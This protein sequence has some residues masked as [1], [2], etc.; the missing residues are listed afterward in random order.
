MNAGTANDS[1]V[2]ADL[3]L[4]ATGAANFFATMTLTET[5]VGSNI[6]TT[7]RFKVELVI[8]TAIQ[9]LITAWDIG[10]GASA[11]ANPG[12]NGPPDGYLNGYEGNA[13]TDVVTQVVYDMAIDDYDANR[14][15]DEFNL[16]LQPATDQ[17]TSVFPLGFA[18]PAEANSVQIKIYGAGF[19]GSET[20]TVSDITLSSPPVPIDSDGDGVSDS[21]ETI[22]GTDLND[23]LDV[24]RLSQS[25]AAPNIF[26]FPTENLRFYRVFVSNDLALWSDSGLPVLTG[27]GTTKQI[28]VNDLPARLRRFFRLQVSQ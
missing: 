25:A 11:I 8:D 19:S 16:T 10:D 26:T 28:D 9:N 5:S 2:I 6:E 21:D 14:D 18:I 24:L 4:S 13:G 15:R 12:P 23:P 7:D 22:M 27:D 3:D 1:I 17:I 20:V